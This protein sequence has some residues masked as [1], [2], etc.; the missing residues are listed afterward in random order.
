MNKANPIRVISVLLMVAGVAIATCMLVFYGFLRPQMPIVYHHQN[1][2]EHLN[3]DESVRAQL[4]EMD[5]EFDVR[6]E[7]LL[8]RFRQETSALAKLLTEEDA[9]NAEIVAA[10]DA[11]HAVHGEL[12]ALSVERYFAIL[13]RIPEEKRPRLRQV[14]A[15]ALSQPE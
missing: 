2:A 10:I 8:V 1:I 15:E 14:A 5:R 9:F 3:L 11:V 4:E 7:A 6:R 13:E 12:Q